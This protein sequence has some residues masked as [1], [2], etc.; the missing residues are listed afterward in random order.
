MATPN[1]E[2]RE[3]RDL[4]KISPAPQPR[5]DAIV[6]HRADMHEIAIRLHY[7]PDRDIL[8]P[9]SLATYLD[10]MWKIKDISLEKNGADHS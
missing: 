7:V 2:I 8:C 5:H 4:L 3:R 10:A 1:T 6:N 9:D